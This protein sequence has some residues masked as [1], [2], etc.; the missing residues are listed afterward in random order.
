MNNLH[1]VLK[2]HTGNAR[3]NLM[4]KLEANYDKMQQQKNTSYMLKIFIKHSIT[5]YIIL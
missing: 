3:T 5:F 2:V 4:N 1:E